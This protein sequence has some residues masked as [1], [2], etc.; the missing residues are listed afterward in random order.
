M[1]DLVRTRSRENE[2]VAAVVNLRWSL[3]LMPVCTEYT[4]GAQRRD[5]QSLGEVSLARSGHLYPFQPL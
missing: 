3:Y 4:L 5:F 2:A 1:G